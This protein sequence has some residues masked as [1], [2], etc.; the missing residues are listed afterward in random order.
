MKPV[1]F[2]RKGF[3][4]STAF[5]F[6]VPSISTN[7]TME[8]TSLDFSLPLVGLTRTDYTIPNLARA[9]WA[10]TLANYSNTTDVGVNISGRNASLPDVDNIAGPTLATVQPFECSSTIKIRF[11]GSCCHYKSK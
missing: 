6:S 4:H 2:W 1:L 10:L 11:P 3:E 8:Q 9:A 7:C 5:T